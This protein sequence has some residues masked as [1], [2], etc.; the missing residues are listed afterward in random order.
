M[1]NQQI[2]DRVLT[3]LRAQ[4]EA[5][6]VAYFSDPDNSNVSYDCRYRLTKDDGR[7][8]MC[9][10]GCLIPDDKYDPK[11]EGFRATSSDVMPVMMV[12]LG[13]E[14]SE[15]DGEQ[16]WKTVDLIG[17]LQL[18]HDTQL[19]EDGL[20]EW[21]ERMATIAGYHKLTYMPA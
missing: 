4:G 10:A 12:S 1:T 13:I 17:D 2:F 3:H 9:A 18:A 7:K 5:A 21:E 14:Q 20:S 19:A 15:G 8:L 6:A 11:L 16:V